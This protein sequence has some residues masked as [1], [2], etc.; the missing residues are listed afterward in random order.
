MA[1][2]IYNTLTRKKEDFKPIKKGEVGF[3]QC[4]PTVYWTQH[5]GNIR[6]MVMADVIV[7]TLKYL[8]YEVN[9]VRNYT[10]VGHLTSDEDFGEDKLEKGARREG[11]TPQEIADK[12]IKIFENDVHNV[13]TLPT[14]VSPRATESVKE[15]IKMVE[16]LLDKGFAYKTD[17][18][19]YFDVSKAKDYTRLS[20]QKQEENIAGAGTG[21]VNDPEKINPADF[22]LWFFKK[23]VHQNAIQTWNSPWGE[24]FPGWHIECSAMSKKFIGETIDI[25]MGGVEHIP[26]H[27]TNEIAQSE[28]ANDKNFVNY[29]IHNEHLLVDGGKM[30]KSQG[31]SYSVQEIKEKGYKP[32]SLRYFFL[33]AHYR[34]K[35]NF[36][37]DAMRASQTGL[38][39]LYGQVAKLD[40]DK[41]FLEK[42]FSFKGRIDEKYKKEFVEKLEDDF[43]TPQAL[44]VVSSLL[45]SNLSDKDKLATILDF[46]KVLG[47]NLHNAKSNAPKIFSEEI[48][49][50][51][52]VMLME[53]RKE[54]R[55]NKNY[56]EADRLRNEIEKLGFEIK[57]TSEGQKIFKK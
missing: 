53:K 13:N 20:H 47:L 12:Y 54:A 29:W 33:Q 1:L 4:G 31:T 5:L 42:I 34:S 21:D 43:N 10:D 11:K 22:V 8:D 24:G 39:N 41:T 16:T 40:S 45:K 38:I 7:R 57:D 27:H 2:K 55:D 25:H 30:S 52:I 19:I 18:A 36:T 14:T 23:G 37:W 44:S 6:A 48:I 51:N 17:L 26:V 15:I 28:S 46:D 32:L 50:H 49:P 56:E 35:Q 3:Y 9:F